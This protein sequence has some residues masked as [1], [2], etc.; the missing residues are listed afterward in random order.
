MTFIQPFF[1]K[2]LTKQNRAKT[3]KKILLIVGCLILCAQAAFS[4]NGS[5]HLPA[6][7][8]RASVTLQ[9]GPT[10]F[11]MDIQQEKNKYVAYLLNAGERLKLDEI[12]L[13][14]DSVIF[15]LHV[16]DAVLAGKIV[17]GSRIEGKWIKFR[18]K[19]TDEVPFTAA[20]GEKER[21]IPTGKK[22]EAVFS[23]KW[24]V[25]FT[26]DNG[27]SYPAV[28]IFDQKGN[29]ITGTFLTSTG[30]YRYLEGIVEGTEM[31]LSTFDGSHGFLMKAGMSGPKQ[32]KGEFWAGRLGHETFTG[33]RNDTATL[34]DADR[35][36]FLKEGY[37]KV[38]FSFPNLDKQAVS[39]QDA[40]FKG[41][42]LILQ[43][44]GSWCPNCMDETAFL[45]PWYTKNKKKGVEI[46][47]L[48]YERYPDFEDAKNR[49]AKLKEKYRIEY[50]LL[51]AGINNKDEASKTLPMLN[52]VLAY[53][54]TIF[55]DKKG[56]VRKIHTGFTGLGTGVYYEKFVK[57]F[58]D[59]VNQLVAEK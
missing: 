59:F 44:M 32:F 14:G 28:G 33:L 26:D 21:F 36:T 7:I 15:S 56:Q 1:I 10:P 46:I 5:V 3:L 29:K 49:V 11:L 39:P 27:K 54:T 4:Q 13:T 38:T 40:K 51:I 25:T 50:E 37:D 23:G 52:R 30:D 22:A 48:A 2:N 9:G 58:N 31:Q 12:T 55:I 19:T 17:N 18:H 43:I 6:G 53:P 47:G 42:V 16:F 41:K 34:P 35:L 20:Y 57:E 24:S 45:A 8:W